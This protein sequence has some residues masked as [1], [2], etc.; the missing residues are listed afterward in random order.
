MRSSDT[1][2]SPL[3]RSLLFR[4]A[5]P[6]VLSASVLR[7]SSLFLSSDWLAAGDSGGEPR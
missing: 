6:S 7:L 5:R 1:R 2:F 4:I 3:S